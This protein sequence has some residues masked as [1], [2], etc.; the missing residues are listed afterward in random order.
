MKLQEIDDRIDDLQNEIESL[1]KQRDLALF[2]NTDYRGKYL[3]SEMDGYM[4]VVDQDIEDRG[5]SKVPILEGVTFSSEL[6][7]SFDG[8]YLF[9]DC[10]GIWDVISTDFFKQTVVEISEKEFFKAW[11]RVKNEFIKR[12][13][14]TTSINRI[15]S[16]K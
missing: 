15:K 14:L 3:K 6:E 10:K 12:D 7:K 2:M 4:Y 5:N 16:K 11:E 1:K 8:E 9:F 13:Y